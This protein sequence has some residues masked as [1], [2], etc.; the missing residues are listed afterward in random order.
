[1]GL[2]KKEKL[3]LTH[4]LY[5]LLILFYN[6][7]LSKPFALKNFCHLLFNIPL[8]R[9][10]SPQ[11]KVKTMEQVFSAQHNNHSL[12][13][14]SVCREYFSHLSEVFSFYTYHQFIIEF[15]QNSPWCWRVFMIEH[16]SS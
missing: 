15:F 5:H 6:Y 12:T 10:L 1:M 7:K 8:T 9:L 3:E 2:V 13:T 11:K 16:L 14:E 4:I